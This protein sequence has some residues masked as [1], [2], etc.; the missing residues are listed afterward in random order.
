[1]HDDNNIIWYRDISENYF[2]GLS[3]LKKCKD[4]NT[5]VCY[6]RDSNCSPFYR[7]SRLCTSDEIKEANWN[8][9]AP[10]SDNESK[11]RPSFTFVNCF[12]FGV[13]STFIITVILLLVMILVSFYCWLS[14]WFGCNCFCSKKKHTIIIWN[15][16]LEIKLNNC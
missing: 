9:N 3:N 5:E 10:N 7:L 6:Y 4:D 12:I 2:E 13:K 14:A 15:L 11:G 8:V 16:K 1:M